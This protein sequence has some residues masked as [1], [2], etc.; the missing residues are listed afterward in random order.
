LE[1]YDNL[2]SVQLELPMV[3]REHFNRWYASRAYYLAL[4]F[5]DIPALILNNALFVSL[6]YFATNQPMEIFRVSM[7]FLIS[8][9]VGFT[10]QGLGILLGSLSN[11]HKSLLYA[12][13]G[14]AGTTLF[15]GFFVLMKD[16]STYWHWLFQASFLKHALDADF[17]IIFGFN[18]TK[19]ECKTKMY[20]HYQ[21]PTKFLEM[22]GVQTTFHYALA[23]IIFSLFL[24]RILAFFVINYRLKH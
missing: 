22:L 16:T 1:I 11:I 4:T 24:F 18:R 12:S 8:V 7:F 13:A 10:A 14:I 15:S 9:L 23:M 21:L 5:V 2:I 17:L 3:K 19:L 20:C 6:T